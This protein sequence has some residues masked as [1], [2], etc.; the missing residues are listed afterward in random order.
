MFRQTGMNIR[1]VIENRNIKI[2]AVIQMNL[3]NGHYFA[4]ATVLFNALATCSAGLACL[5]EA[6]QQTSASQ[7]RSRVV[8][9]EH[10]V[11]A[12]LVCV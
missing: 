10:V 7:V 3:W 12:S 9:L 4:T 2:T 1:G 11:L 8:N 6:T 5:V